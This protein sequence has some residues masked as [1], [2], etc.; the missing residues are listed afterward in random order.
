ME[1]IEL[2]LFD[3]KHMDPVEHKR[4]TGL[5][6]TLIL[7]NL[8]NLFEAGKELRI[9]VPLMPGINDTDE[10]IGAM[11][12]FLHRHG[13]FAVDVLPCHTFGFN[14]YRALNLSPPELLPYKP[15][16]L[17]AALARFRRHGLRVTIAK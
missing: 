13:C 14:K 12:E 7:H 8:H 1:K 4:L 6:N 9:R 3:C 11:A 17:E 10:N 2:F 5:D 15:E 16:E